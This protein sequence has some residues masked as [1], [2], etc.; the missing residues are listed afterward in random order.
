MTTTDPLTPSTSGAPGFGDQL[1]EIRALISAVFVAGPPVLVGWAGTALLALLL[2]GPFA[3]LVT[4]VVAL[5][6]ATAVVALAAA[7][8]ATPFLLVRHV[9]AHWPRRTASDTEPQ[10]VAVGSPSAVA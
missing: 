7:I 5:V 10:L 2:T 9:R 8:L 3:L 4:L 1:A 6:A